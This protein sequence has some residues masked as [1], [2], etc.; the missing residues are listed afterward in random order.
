MSLIRRTPAPAGVS[1]FITLSPRRLDVIFA[2]AVVAIALLIGWHGLGFSHSRFDVPV[3][4]D[5]DAAQAL[6]RVESNREDGWYQPVSRAGMPFGTRYTDLPNADGFNLVLTRVLGLF[7]DRPGSLFNL[8]VLAGFALTS[9]IALAVFRRLG[10]A[11]PWAGLASLTFTLLPFHFQH[12]DRPFVAMYFSAAMAAWLA[13]DV[14]GRNPD[15]SSRPRIWRGVVILAAILC[16]SSGT[17]YAFYACLIVYAAGIAMSIETTSWLPVRR[18]TLIAC[19]VVATVAIQIA[20]AWLATWEAGG[21]IE[22][23]APS[24]AESETHGLKF[25]QLVMPRQAH[26]L[27]PLASLRDGYDQIAPLTNENSASSLGIIGSAGLIVLMLAPFLGRWRESLPRVVRNSVAPVWLAFLYATVGGLA[28][29]F[30]FLISPQ[31]SEPSLIAPFIAFFAILAAAMLF[32]RWIDK[33]SGSLRRVPYL[34]ALLLLVVGYGDQ[35]G[36]SDG[37]WALTHRTHAAQFEQSAAFY[38]KLESS[39]PA[40]S[41]VALLPLTSYPQEPSL[42]ANFRPFDAYLQTSTLRWTSGALIGRPGERWQKLF[43]SFPLATRINTLSSLGFAGIVIDRRGYPDSGA[44]VEA[45]LP[46]NGLGATFRSEDETLGYYPLA[47]SKHSRHRSFAVVPVQGWS[48]IEA[49]ENEV[50]MWSTGNASLCWPMQVESSVDAILN[51]PSNPTRNRARYRCANMI[52]QSPKFD[53]SPAST[54]QS[55]PIS[56]R[57]QLRRTLE[58]LTDVPA[59]SPGIA[60]PRM[61]A[62]RMIMQKPPLCR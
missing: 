36:T 27:K 21:N 37:A 34:A 44:A 35:V 41:M 55:P 17:S 25:S 40:D 26:Q 16:G 51:F 32:G 9:L 47:N 1:R 15:S 3:A 54:G 52:G 4:L 11:R 7:A 22:L 42:P 5:N 28:S 58:L 6:Y 45:Q 33:R 14:V 39:V 30:A 59:K 57:R 20:P 56:I 49:N 46:E 61:L 48:E 2:V 8:L 23:S 18:A 53:W 60:D 24:A 29:L 50:W 19:V 38:R 12:V 13:L 10:L 31:L 43:E 62:F